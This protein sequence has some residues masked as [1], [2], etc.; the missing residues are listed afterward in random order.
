VYTKINVVIEGWHKVPFSHCC[1]NE[2]RGS[3]LLFT[4][5]SSSA[6]PYERQRLKNLATAAVQFKKL[7]DEDKSRR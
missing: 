4:P 7:C 3:Y 2:A 6:G 1:M 5:E